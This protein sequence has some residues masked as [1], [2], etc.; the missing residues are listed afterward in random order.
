[1]VE[2]QMSEKRNQVSGME[3]DFLDQLSRELD[4]G[5]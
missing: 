5:R 3:E 2:L 4:N 1:M